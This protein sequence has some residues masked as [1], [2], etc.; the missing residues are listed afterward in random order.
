M[1]FVGMLAQLMEIELKSKMNHVFIHVYVREEGQNFF[2][3]ASVFICLM[4]ILILWQSVSRER[5][6]NHSHGQVDY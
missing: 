5:N 3:G 6:D 1:H 2:I 4:N